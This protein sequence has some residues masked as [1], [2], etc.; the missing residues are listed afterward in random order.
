[1]EDE[2]YF[3]DDQGLFRGKTALATIEEKFGQRITKLRNDRA[4]TQEDLS[5]ESGVSVRSISSIEN[6]K[7]STTL[8]TIEK[9]AKGF[10]TSVQSLFK[11]E[12]GKG[13]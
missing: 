1:M 10:G 11:D 9:L 5:A 7:F 6:A 3:T 2:A 12:K 4:W 8:E 13:Y